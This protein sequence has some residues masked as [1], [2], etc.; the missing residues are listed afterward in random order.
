MKLYWKVIA[1]FFIS[2]EPW[3]NKNN[4]YDKYVISICKKLCKKHQ[5]NVWF[6]MP[7]SFLSITHIHSITTCVENWIEKKE[8]RSDWNVLKELRNTTESHDTGNWII[9]E[10]VKRVQCQ[11]KLRHSSGSFDIKSYDNDNS[12]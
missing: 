6:V 2:K 8:K 7:C 1:E 4:L 9:I 11:S 3:Y 5:R 12:F 10:Y